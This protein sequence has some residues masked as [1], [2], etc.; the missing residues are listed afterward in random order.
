VSNSQFSNDEEILLEH[1]FDA[2]RVHFINREG[3]LAEY[4]Q[5]SDTNSK[6]RFLRLASV[7]RSLVKSGNFVP[8][9]PL[10]TSFNYLDITY[11][12]IALLSIIEAVFSKDEW[13]GFHQWLCKHQKANIF[14]IKD[15]T[16]LEELY[17]Q[18]NSEYGATKNTVKFFKA[19]EKVEQEFLVERLVRLRFDGPDNERV[20]EIE[21]T[22]FDFAKRLYDIR[23]EFVHNAKLIVEFGNIPAITVNRGK[24]FISN[25]SLD[26][27]MSV[28][29]VGFI[30]H[31]GMRPECQI[32]LP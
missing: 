1:A 25:L 2:L 21:S 13:L 6:S 8:G 18:Y 10:D 22:I 20:L 5:I 15:Q 19:L 26:D 14:P 32:L 30:R 7:Y 16:S 29:E 12:Y 17:S 3:F 23:S 4:K 31:F 27:L 28:F 11:K 24:P 9:H